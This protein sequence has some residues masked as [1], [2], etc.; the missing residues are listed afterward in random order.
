[1]LPLLRSRNLVSF[2][3]GTSLCPPAYLK[4]DNGNITDKVNPDFD[5]W[6]QQDATV[7]SWINSSVHPTVLAALIG[8]TSSHSAWTTLRDQYAS[9]STGRLLQL[10]SELMNTHRGDSSISEFLDKVNCLAD[11][12]SLS[13]APVSDSD[14][15]AI[16]LNNVGP[17]YESTVAS[18]QARDEAITYSALEA[19]LLGA[20]RRQKMHTAFGTDNGLTALV[21][22][23]N[24]NRA[25]ASFRGRGFSTGFRGRSH[26]PSGRGSSNRHCNS[27]HFHQ[28]SPSNQGSHFHHGSNPHP[29]SH[30]RQNDGILG[31]A[32]SHGPFTTGRIQCQICSRHGHSAIDCFNRLNMSYEGRVPAPRLQ[33]FAATAPS[34]SATAPAI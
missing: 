30:S 9:Q 10:R 34:A 33:A 14:V 19:L 1:M 6:I 18:A 2:V 25:P 21:A 11:T 26:F 20:E 29:G 15:V 22:G 12:L 4:D 16:I 23:R 27:P 3:D 31:P 17:A 7:M 28:G 32:P 8:K 13:G 5:T 24:G